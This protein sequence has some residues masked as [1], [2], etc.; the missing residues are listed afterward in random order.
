[1]LHQTT[2][3]YIHLEGNESWMHL[4]YNE[5]Y[6]KAARWNTK[7]LFLDTVFS[8][9]TARCY[10]NPKGANAL[11]REYNNKKR[12]KWSMGIFLYIKCQA[13]SPNHTKKYRC[14]L[15]YFEWW[16]CCWFSLIAYHGFIS[17]YYNERHH[18]KWRVY[19][20]GGTV[21]TLFSMKYNLEDV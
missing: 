9:F 5:N 4:H 20:I 8:L 10:L 14:P 19:D 12:G 2:V 3:L 13:A 6:E 18:G 16:L 11:Y 17:W 21:K 7:Y 1:M 15:T